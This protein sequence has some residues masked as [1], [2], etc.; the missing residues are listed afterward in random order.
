MRLQGSVVD[1]KTAT[2]GQWLR[3]MSAEESFA[4]AFAT[5]L[6]YSSAALAGNAAE[7][8]S[9]LIAGLLLCSVALLGLCSSLNPRRAFENRVRIKSGN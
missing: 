8:G 5:L 3:E 1:F 4:A 6:V 2:A 7:V 9:L